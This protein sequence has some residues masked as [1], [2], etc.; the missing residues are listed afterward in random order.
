MSLLPS[1]D[2]KLVQE[3]G[4]FEKCIILNFLS[5]LFPIFQKH[6]VNIYI[7]ICVSRFRLNKETSKYG[8]FKVYMVISPFYLVLRMLVLLSDSFLQT[9]Q[10]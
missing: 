7:F 10:H 3:D 9:L 8:E 6:N 1:I 2:H 4:Y 5:Y